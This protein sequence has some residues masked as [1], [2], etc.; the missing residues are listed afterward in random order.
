MVVMLNV[1]MQCAVMLPRKFINPQLTPAKGIIVNKLINRK[2]LILIEEIWQ[3]KGW[4]EAPLGE[5][6]LPSGKIRGDYWGWQEIPNIIK[7]KDYLVV[8]AQ[9]HNIMKINYATLDKMIE[10]SILDFKQV[11]GLT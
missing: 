6:C 8:P 11:H 1:G 9:P 2:V 3:F 7:D 4:R 5:Q 10:K